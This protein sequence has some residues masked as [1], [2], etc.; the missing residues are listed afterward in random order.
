MQGRINI[1]VAEDIDILRK[2]ICE[3]I[4]ECPKLKLVGE[5]CCGRELIKI[6]EQNQVDVVLTDIEMDDRYDGIRAARK[7]VE[8]SPHT[9]IIFL[10]VHEDDETIFEAFSTSKNVDYILKTET[11]QHIIQRILDI[12][13]GKSSISPQI[14]PKIKSEFCRLRR[15]EESLLFIVN[16][17]GELT[18]AERELI[19]LLLDGKKVAQIAEKR[20]VEIVTVKSQIGT[21]LKKF[22][23]KRTKQIVSLIRKLKLEYLFQ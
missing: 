9:V 20:N 23:M 14:A 22:N 12:C 4:K 7:I 15:S 16:I 21:M 2:D 11:H 8:L 6:V 5:A 13:E 1:V 19:K 10:T 3:S 17:I 18:P